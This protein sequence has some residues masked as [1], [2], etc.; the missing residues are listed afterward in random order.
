M[1]AYFLAGA[2]TVLLSIIFGVIIGFRMGQ[3]REPLALPSLTNSDD[4]PE[5]DPEEYKWAHRKE[6]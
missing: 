6:A 1:L 3:G 5:E 4:P 2:I